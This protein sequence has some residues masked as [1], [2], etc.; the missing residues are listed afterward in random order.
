MF[1]RRLAAVCGLRMVQTKCPTKVRISTKMSSG[2]KVV[3]LTQVAAVS[4][5][6]SLICPRQPQSLLNI[7]NNP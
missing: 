6:A 5:C 3:C 2:D 1:I 7:G 4:L